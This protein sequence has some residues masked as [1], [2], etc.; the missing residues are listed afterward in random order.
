MTDDY[1]HPGPGPEY[2]C[3]AD[4]LRIWR[5]LADIG[6]EI[7]QQHCLDGRPY[8]DAVW[9]AVPD[10]AIVAGAVWYAVEAGVRRAYGLDLDFDPDWTPE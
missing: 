3:S 4:A 2:W 5:E 10:K 1:Y 7:G 8:A 6:H 9:A